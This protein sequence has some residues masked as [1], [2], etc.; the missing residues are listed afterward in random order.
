MKRG[1]LYFRLLDTGRF[2]RF[3][4]PLRRL[5]ARFAV[6]SMAPIY[7]HRARDG[8][9]LRPMHKPQPRE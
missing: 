4:H 3:Q 1:K 2:A 7:R 5:R 8:Y 9:R 6:Y